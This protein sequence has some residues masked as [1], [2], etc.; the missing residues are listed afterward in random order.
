MADRERSAGRKGPIYLRKQ[1][2]RRAKWPFELGGILEN[3]F[4]VRKLN[5]KVNFGY[6]EDGQK[7]SALVKLRLCPKCSE[8]LNFH[9]KKRLIKKEPKHIKEET[10]REKHKKKKKKRKHRSRSRSR[11]STLSDIEPMPSTLD[12]MAVLSQET[13]DVVEKVGWRKK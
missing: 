9:S 6:M 5:F 7:K 3:R 2:V 11:S 1:E 12:S 13:V 10:G 4:F 8:K